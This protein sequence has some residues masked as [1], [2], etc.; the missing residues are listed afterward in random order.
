M[1][2]DA[3][4]SNRIKRIESDRNGSCKVGSYANTI[5][6]RFCD[7]KVFCIKESYFNSRPI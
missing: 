5:L 4:K 2:H 7:T 3:F 6:S 1:V